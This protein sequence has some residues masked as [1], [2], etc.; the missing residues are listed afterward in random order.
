MIRT[1]FAVLLVCACAAAFS[2][3]CS[4]GKKDVTYNPMPEGT[5]QVSGE[6]GN[7]KE[8]PPAPVAPAAKDQ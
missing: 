4:G 6:R 1:V 3:G 2:T 8:A 7:A 5:P